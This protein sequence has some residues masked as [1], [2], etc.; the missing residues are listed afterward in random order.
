MAAA[1]AALNGRVLAER[2]KDKTIIVIC[3]L[4][5]SLYSSCSGAHATDA[6]TYKPAPKPK[7]FRPTTA[8]EEYKTEYLKAPVELPGVPTYSGQRLTF[9]RGFR[10][11][12]PRSGMKIGLN[13]LALEDE[14]TILAW[15]RQALPMYKWKMTPSCPTQVWS[16]AR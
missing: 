12:N 4:T 10:Y 13:Y 5:A 8:N 16:R 6:K 7:A 9:E 15:Y 3:A 14:Q 1:A 2:M 11:P